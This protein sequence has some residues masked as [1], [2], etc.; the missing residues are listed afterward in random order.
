MKML[1]G[2]KIVLSVVIS[3]AVLVFSYILENTSFPLPDEMKVLKYVDKSRSL[4]GMNHH[5]VPDSFMMIN[6]CFDKQLVDYEEN[7]M[8]VGQYVITDRSKLLRFLR[9]A[10]EKDNY[11]YIMLDVIFEKGFQTPCDS[12]LFSLIAAM[13]RIVVASHKD[14]ILQDAMLFEKSGNADYTSTWEETDFTRYQFLHKGGVESI[15]LRMYKELTGRNITRHGMFY[16]CDGRLCRNA[17]TLKQPI[18]MSG[19]ISYY[20]EEKIEKNYL[21]LGKDLLE[22]DSIMPVSEQIEGKIIVVGDF[23]LDR[24]DTYLGVQAGSVICANAYN[25]LCNGEHYI[26]WYFI[27]FLFVLYAFIAYMRINNQHFFNENLHIAIKIILSLFSVPALLIVVAVIAY[28][29]GIVYNLYIPTFVY[30]ICDFISNIYNKCKTI[31]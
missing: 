3:M 29:C 5:N 27:A 20:N 31:K 10:H 1:S 19:S 11:R 17:L 13:P 7:G 24:H 18:R 28:M 15:S 25:A 16:T 22:T 12:A 8:P 6:V 26:N 4:V 2:K 30:W 21:Y 23:M 9:L 14:V